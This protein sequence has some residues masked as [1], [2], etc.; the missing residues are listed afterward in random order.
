MSNDILGDRG[1]ALQ[2]MFFAQQNE[3]LRKALREK[4]EATSEK[5]ALSSASG[6]A[7]DA[8]L[9]QLVA[10]NIRSDTLAALSLVPLIEVAWA[11]GIMEEMQRIAILSA[12]RDS[13][14]SSESAALLD[15]WLVTQPGSEVFSAWKDYVSALTSKM[16][17][18]VRDKLEQ[19]LLNRARTVAESAGGFLGI[20]AIS[21]KEEEVLKELSR[22]FS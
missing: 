11:D 17:M 16:D 13:G 14:I 18:E 15:G 6:I 5:E 19:D 21:S 22:A 20:S 2:E 1:R 9:E 4:E 8:L 12:A 7:D 3:N 10:L